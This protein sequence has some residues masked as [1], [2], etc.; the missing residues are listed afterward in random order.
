[1]LKVDLDLI[2]FHAQITFDQIVDAFIAISFGLYSKN[3]I[4]MAVDAKYMNKT[5]TYL[6]AHIH[7]QKENR[8]YHKII[9]RFF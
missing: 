1:M 7:T 2:I 3:K 6:L 8:T 4:K 9:F 5:N